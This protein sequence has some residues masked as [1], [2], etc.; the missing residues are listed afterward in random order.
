MTAMKQGNRFRRNDLFNEEETWSFI[1]H[2][3]EDCFASRRTC[4]KWKA[5]S[6]VMAAIEQGNRFHRND[7][8]NEEETWSFIKHRHE[9]D[10][11]SRR[12]YIEGKHETLLLKRRLFIWFSIFSIASVKPMMASISSYWLNI[13]FLS[14][15]HLLENSM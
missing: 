10:F 2:S 15:R 5:W 14:F 1:K 6:F 12:A 13:L 4:I 8:F 11:A 9:D 3:H 7:L